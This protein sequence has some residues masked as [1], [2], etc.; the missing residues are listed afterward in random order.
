MKSSL[1]FLLSY[2]WKDISTIGDSV[3]KLNISRIVKKKTQIKISCVSKRLQR[4]LDRYNERIPIKLQL[5]AIALKWPNSPSNIRHYAKKARMTFVPYSFSV[6]LAAECVRKI[7]TQTY[8]L[9]TLFPIP[10]EDAHA[11]IL[12]WYLSFLFMQIPQREVISFFPAIF[13]H[14]VAFWLVQPPPHG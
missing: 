1:H 14:Y 13:P 10:L 8:P 4:A 6:F 12:W 9:I 5:V 3:S 7:P 11:M 2:D